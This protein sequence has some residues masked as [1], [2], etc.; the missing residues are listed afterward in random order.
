MFQY[1]NR[2][3]IVPITNIQ[4]WNMRSPTLLFAN[5]I[6]LVYLRS[7]QALSHPLRAKLPHSP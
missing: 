3:N 5:D 4:K 1:T 2:G 7:L 6:P